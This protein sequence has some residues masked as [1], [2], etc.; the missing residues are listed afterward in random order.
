M[1]DFSYRYYIFST[2]I[3]PP[4]G[5]ITSY[6]TVTIKDINTPGQALERGGVASFSEPRG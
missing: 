1:S 2:S 4:I 3:V 5:F 6:K